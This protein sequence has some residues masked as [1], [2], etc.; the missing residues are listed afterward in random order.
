MR[1]KVLVDNRERNQDIL[2]KLSQEMETEMCQLPVADYIV[3]DRVG[4]ERKTLEDFCGSII[5]ARLFEQADR[6]RKSFERPFIL[7]EGSGGDR[8]PENVVFGT[9]IALYVDYG[10]QVIRSSGPEDTA[11]IIYAIAK[12]EQEEKERGVR[13]VGIK[14]AHTN[15]EWQQFI[16]GA[17]PGVGPKLAKNLL[18]HFGTIRELANADQKQL[19]E[20]DKVGKKKAEAIYRMMNEYFDAEAHPS[21]NSARAMPSA[22]SGL[23]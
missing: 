14:K 8:L 17:M 20:V 18:S 6:L 11:S 23:N 21:R 2:D 4:I 5:N 19:A 7:L 9:I 13:M 16:V 12:R 10:V 22:T 3:S 1:F 15:D